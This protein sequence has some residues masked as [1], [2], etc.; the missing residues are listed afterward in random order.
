M[1]ADIDFTAFF[2]ATPSPYLVLDTDLVI[3]YVNPACLRTAGRTEEELVGKYFFDALPENPGI[4][5]EAE[6]NLK[7]SL[8]RLLDTG[9]PE[10]VVLERYDLP[11][12]D[13]PDGFEER[14]WSVIHTPLSGPDGKVKWIIQQMEDVTAF[15]HSPRTRQCSMEQAAGMSAELY[16]RARELDRLNQELRQAHAR[17]QQVAVTLQEAMLFVPDLDRHSNIA[18]RYLPAT[19]SLNVCGDWYDVVDLPPD[20][21]AVAVG[22]VVGHGL[23]AAAVMGM[24]RSALSAVIRAIPSPAQ[25]LEV[26]G[27]YARSVDGAMAATAVKV[28]IDTRSKLIIYSN[29]GHLPPVLLHSDGT[30]E[31][32]DKATDPP[33]GAREHHVPRPQAGVGYAPGDTLVLYTDGLIERRDEDIDTGIER[34]S[35]ALAQDQA[36]SPDLLADALLARLDVADGAPDDI[37]LVIIRL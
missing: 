4:H 34:L 20:R 2:D 23:S 10:T 12:P 19:A 5:D 13:Q 21:Y 27:L 26:L 24:L 37:A 36:L 18:V 14:W 35:T 32:L 28:L 16:A 22:D 17:E 15:V 31:L 8:L 1:T 7:A 11:R 33:L 29:A 9:E 6:R 25:A 30:C 3:R